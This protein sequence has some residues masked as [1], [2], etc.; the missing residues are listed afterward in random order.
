MQAETAH[1]NEAPA[2]MHLTHAAALLGVAPELLRSA[3]LLRTFDTG[4]ERMRRTMERDEADVS[5]DGLCRTLYTRLFDWLVGRMNEAL[6]PPPTAPLVPQP[7][8][9]F[10]PLP[11]S[12]SFPSSP[13][14]P[15]HVRGPPTPLIH[16][17]R[18]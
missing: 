9:L 12:P 10:P 13:L 17:P 11:T 15:S 6:Q 4:R 18:C 7:H 1:D 5:R 3:L 8:P 14:S 16:L 2:D